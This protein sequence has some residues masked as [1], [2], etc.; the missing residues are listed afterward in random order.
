MESEYQHKI[1]VVDDDKKIAKAFEDV[2]QK[3]KIDH[4]F[5]NS[6]DAALEEVKKAEK[7][8]SVIITDQGMEG[9]TGTQTLEHAR[10]IIPETIRVLMTSHS[11]I[12]TII[13]A[14]NKGAIQ[15]F[16]VKPWTEESLDK[17]VVSS[18]KLYNLFLEDKKLLKHAK[19]QRK[20]LYEL[21]YQL[22]EA[23]KSN[24][25]IIHE[26]D[27]EIKTL[28][29]EIKDLSMKT[30]DNSSLTPEQ[31]IN[32]IQTHVKTDQGIDL[33]KTATLLKNT[34]KKLYDQFNEISYRNG[35]EMPDIKGEIN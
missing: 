27:N 7:P 26:L 12:D 2:F 1:L 11:Q 34:I 20:K 17:A 13:N 24:N 28:N 22:I 4:I 9:M 35:F 10:E 31:I 30:P 23:T 16:I 14:V 25:R 6:G 15:N 21:D 33:E 5:V 19:K 32:E 3:K 29:S 18:I 8:F